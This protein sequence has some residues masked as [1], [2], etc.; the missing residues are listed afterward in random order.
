VAT[1]RCAAT[2]SISRNWRSRPGNGA[3]IAVPAKAAAQSTKTALRFVDLGVELGEEWYPKR[4]KI[5]ATWGPF[6]DRDVV[7]FMLD[8]R[9]PNRWREEP[10]LSRIIA[11]YGMRTGAYTTEARIA[12]Y[13]VAFASTPPPDFRMSKHT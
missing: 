3:R 2:Y 5:V 12:D 8:P 4:A 10:Y 9:Y 7:R 13:T 1:A 6:E 11:H